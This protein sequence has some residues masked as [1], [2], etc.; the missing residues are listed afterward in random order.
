MHTLSVSTKVTVPWADAAGS[1]GEAAAVAWAASWAGAACWAACAVWAVRESA[2]QAV[3][4]IEATRA[5][6]A[7]AEA[8]PG[9]G[10]RNQRDRDENRGVLMRG[11]PE[12]AVAAVQEHSTGSVPGPPVT[13][14]SRGVRASV[15]PRDARRG[16]GGR[17]KPPDAAR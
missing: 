3:K 10:V 15:A 14:K 9:A 1:A 12:N 7:T 17:R 16:R 5:V 2:L 13:Y 4:A 11:S 6:T 8:K